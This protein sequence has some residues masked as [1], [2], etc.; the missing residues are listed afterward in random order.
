M[1]NDTVLNQLAQRLVQKLKQNK[2]TLAAAES[3]TGGWLS[4]C[5]TDVSG[6]SAVFTA[7]IVTYSNAAKEQLLNVPNGLLNEHGAVSLPVAEA[8]VTGALDVSGANLTVAITGIAGPSGGSEAKP[9][10]T[11]CFAWGW[12]AETKARTIYSD[13]K[14]FAG[15]RDMVRRQAVQQALEEALSLVDKIAE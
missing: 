11:V 7:G 9:V 3:C 5:I 14:L 2:L 13:S 4:K 8:M 10:G 12:Q 6:S 1:V 15:D